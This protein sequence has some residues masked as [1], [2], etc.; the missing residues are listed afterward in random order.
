MLQPAAADE[1]SGLV[2]N[3]GQVVQL[4]EPRTGL[5]AELQLPGEAALCAPTWAMT[6][7]I[8]GRNDLVRGNG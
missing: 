2:E 1:V 6:V 5:I 4:G 3:L 7:D 8:E